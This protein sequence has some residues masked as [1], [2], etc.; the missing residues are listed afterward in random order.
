MSG[1]GKGVGA[2]IN[3]RRSGF[4]LLEVIITLAVMILFVGFFTLRFDDGRD[5]EL[6]SRVTVGIKSAALKSKKRSFTFRRNQYI[7]FADRAFWTTEVPPLPDDPLPSPDSAAERF[8]LPEGV[9]MQILPP[10]EERW[11]TPRGYVWTFRSSGLSDPLQ[12][13]FTVEGS[14][15]ALDFNVLT[16]L[17]EEQTVLQ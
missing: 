8:A 6:L 17:A 13:K 2:S 14:F 4:T 15:S 5:E 9:G 10:G 12:V 11:R 3:A 16:A 1:T 7:V